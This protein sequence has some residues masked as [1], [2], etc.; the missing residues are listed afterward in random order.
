MIACHV[1]SL[2]PLSWIY[3]CKTS[4][5][6][7]TRNLQQHAIVIYTST[8][9]HMRVTRPRVVPEG[10]RISCDSGFRSSNSGISAE[11]SGLTVDTQQPPISVPRYTMA[12][13][14]PFDRSYKRACEITIA[15][16]WLHQSFFSQQVRSNR[17]STWPCGVACRTS[18]TKKHSRQPRQK[19]RLIFLLCRNTYLLQGNSKV[20]VYGMAHKKH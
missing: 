17:T 18:L 6:L 19:D 15:S 13:K 1:S 4:W 12:I 9:P 3:W 16:Q 2:T 8:E 10:F 11:L 5:G 20:P 14:M 7:R